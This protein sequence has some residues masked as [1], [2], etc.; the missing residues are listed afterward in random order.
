MQGGMGVQN[1]SDIPQ[2]LPLD[3]IMKFAATPQGQ[4]LL[5]HR[6]ASN[7]GPLVD[8]PSKIHPSTMGATICG[9]PEGAIGYR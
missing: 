6:G 1:P 8:G 4:A 2:G 7:R 9:L 5:A 3:K